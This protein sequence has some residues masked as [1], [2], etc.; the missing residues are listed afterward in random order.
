MLS[1]MFFAEV[2]AVF[3]M[4]RIKAVRGKGKEFFLN[5]LSCNDYYSEKEHVE[6]VWHG[7]LANDFGLSEQK[8]QAKVFSLFQQNINPETGAKLT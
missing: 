6:G 1:S 5:H 3:T 8:V 7:A 4:A 2:K